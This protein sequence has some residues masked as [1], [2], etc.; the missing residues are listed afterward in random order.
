MLHPL[1]KLNVGV[2]QDL[3]LHLLSSSCQ[4]FFLAKLTHSCGCEYRLMILKMYSL[5][6]NFPLNPTCIFNCLLNL[7]LEV[8]MHLEFIISKPDPLF[9][10]LSF[11]L[12]KPVHPKK[13]NL[14]KWQHCLVSYYSQ[15]LARHFCSSLFFLLHIQFCYGYLQI[16]Y[17][18][19]HFSTQVA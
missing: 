3:A 4:T 1:L 17:E 5:T 15:S 6:Q 7:L 11:T 2:L 16:V 14:I 10:M 13:F 8:Q 12:V 19:D 9:L 18:S